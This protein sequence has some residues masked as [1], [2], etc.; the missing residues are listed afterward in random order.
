M[1]RTNVPAAA[2]R[3]VLAPSR[4]AADGAVKGSPR[5][6]RGRAGGGGEERTLERRGRATR[7]MAAI[8]VRCGRVEAVGV[9]QAS[10]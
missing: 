5:A 9:S 10:V 4:P 1:E 3:N 8:V 6:S 2:L 7:A